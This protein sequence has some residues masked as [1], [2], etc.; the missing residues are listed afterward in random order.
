MFM[1]PHYRVQVDS[2]RTMVPLWEAV[3]GHK[4]NNFMFMFSHF[5][6]KFC[7][8][9]LSSKF[10]H[11]LGVSALI[12]QTTENSSRTPQNHMRVKVRC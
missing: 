12:C 1:E 9:N 8:F 5:L 10:P 4:L 6:F 2:N 3:A 7:H 11:T